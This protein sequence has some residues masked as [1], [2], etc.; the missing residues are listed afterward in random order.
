[1]YQPSILQNQLGWPQGEDREGAP[2]DRWLGARRDWGRERQG[3]PNRRALI[4]LVGGVQRHVRRAE[5]RGSGQAS[6]FSTRAQCWRG[7]SATTCPP[8]ALGEPVTHEPLARQAPSETRTTA[9]APT[10][11]PVSKGPPWPASSDLGAQLHLTPQ[12]HA[13]APHTSGPGQLGEQ[14]G[15]KW[16]WEDG[17]SSCYPH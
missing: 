3:L 1:M 11:I 16:V 15:G 14:Q 10:A 4:V 9:A 6:A 7:H 17:W 12:Q 5:L 8:P 2:L 13:A